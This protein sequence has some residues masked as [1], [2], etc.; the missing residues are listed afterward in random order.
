VTTPPTPVSTAVPPVPPVVPVPT[1]V[2]GTARL[3]KYTL[4]FDRPSR[5]AVMKNALGSSVSII[6]AYQPPALVCS[7]LPG[8]AWQAACS[9]SPSRLTVEPILDSNTWWDPRGGAW[10]FDVVL[11]I[12]KYTGAPVT[13]KE[14]NPL[15]DPDATPPVLG[16]CTTWRYTLDY[17]E[18]TFGTDP[19]TPFDAIDSLAT[20][21]PKV[22]V[23]TWVEEP[24]AKIIEDSA[25]RI[26]WGLVAYSGIESIYSAT[27]C[28]RSA[29]INAETVSKIDPLG[30]ANVSAIVAKLRL[31]N[32]GGLQVGG[33]T[34]T[35]LALEKAQ[36]E[37][38]DTF[39]GDPLYNCL[40]NYGTILVTD[41]ESNTCNPANQPWA[42]YS[43]GCPPPEP[44]DPNSDTYKLFPP[45]VAE[46]IWNL[47]L[48]TPCGSLPAR[49]DGPIYPRTWVIGFGKEAGKCELNYTAFK[50]KTDANSP[51]ND[52]GF[53][54]LKDPRLCETPDGVGGCTTAVY[55]DSQ[56]YA[57]FADSTEA[58][59]VAF[60][61]ITNATATGDYATGAPITGAAAGAGKYIILSSTA[62]PDW[63]GHLYK[64]DTSEFGK[65]A[66]NNYRVWDAAQLLAAKDET[67]RLIYTWDPR[68]PDLAL[69]E[70]TEGN[71]GTLG[72]IV[73]FTGGVA[74]TMTPAV[75]DFIRGN[76]GETKLDGT[77]KLP[78]VARAARLGPL[79]NTVP[80]IV[81]SPAAYEQ[82]KVEPHD[83][84]Q[85]AYENRRPMIWIGSNDGMLHAFDF[86]TGDE[87]V[88]IIPPQILGRQAELRDNFNRLIEKPGP[89]VTYE[90]SPTSKTGQPDD[91]T[92]IYGVAGSL[93]FGDVFFPG[94]PGGYRTLGFITL[95]EAGSVVAAIDITHP[96]PG[97]TSPVVDPDPEYGVFPGTT[98]GLPVKIVWQK[99]AANLPGLKT[100]WSLPA[101][102]ARSFGKWSIL[103]GA[104]HDE[105]NV[106]NKAIPIVPNIFQLDPVDGTPV[107]GTAETT[108]DN[109]TGQPWVGNQAFA[110]S[111]QIEH[112][113]SAF[114]S[115]N[116]ADLGLQADLNGQIWFIDPN[117]VNNRMVGIDATAV[118]KA[119]V[120][121]LDAVSQPLYY[122][123]A[124][125]GFGDPPTN[126]QGCNVFSFG[127]GS[128]YEVSNRVNSLST[129]KPGSFIPNLYFAAKSKGSFGTK[130]DSEDVLRIPISTIKR[131]VG[132][133]DTLSER[134]QLAA[135][136]YLLIDPRGI[137]ASVAVFIIY[138]PTVGCNGKSYAVAVSFAAP[139]CEIPL[140]IQSGTSGSTNDTS[141]PGAVVR[142]AEMGEGVAS[143]ITSVGDISYTAVACIGDKADCKAD[144]AEIKDAK[145]VFGTARA[146]QPIWWKELR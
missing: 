38:I 21:K 5:I 133:S 144:L 2:P 120:E 86:A 90:K 31:E 32:E 23:G 138:D 139:S 48:E 1:A 122:P 28:D 33:A 118:A 112:G 4:K 128:F 92:N 136:P 96:Y 146:F 121:P 3:W 54:W 12:W 75:V 63:E 109:Q 42:K 7:E 141:I 73:A 15:C 116:K 70:I 51:N 94:S 82:G 61:K 47:A 87:V 45:G 17:G 44:P 52:A 19:G 25:T 56:D 108:L 59:V 67:K 30:G 69:V 104:G 97:N 95:A 123:P 111:V 83:D 89:P 114:R 58:L 40:R 117:K 6:T 13:V 93:R 22:G 132:C 26:N 8:A 137:S 60:K 77:L 37:L 115:D 125:G 14:I 57:F 103:F 43:T 39:A 41:G 79:I 16:G 140:S 71:R 18:G 11:G 9:A 119:G 49:T 110:D 101:L 100:T 134:S 126:P 68:D 55:K 76:T 10:A 107:A 34:P 50:G 106:F 66:P 62:F 131:C 129:G 78:K 102:A 84:F 142:T 72:N 130:V 98:T 64:L 74:S 124:A 113:A 105:T 20:A 85:K 81:G 88:A 46:D 36:Q 29:S 127:S 135:A 143:G 80:S 53:A 65:P 27:Q 35:R 24:P 145:A 91:L 99:T